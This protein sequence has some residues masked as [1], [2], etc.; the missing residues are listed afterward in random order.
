MPRTDVSRVV[1]SVVKV[2]SP[3]GNIDPLETGTGTTSCG[4]GWATVRLPGAKPVMRHGPQVEQVTVVVIV[5]SWTVSDVDGVSL[6]VVPNEDGWIVGSVMNLVVKSL[7]LWSTD[8]DGWI[9]GSVT[10]LVVRFLLLWSTAEVLTKSMLE[11]MV[12]SVGAAIG[13]RVASSRSSNRLAPPSPRGWGWLGILMGQCTAVCITILV[14]TTGGAVLAPS[15]VVVVA[16]GVG[17]MRSGTGV[18]KL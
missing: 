12:L 10:N 11:V 9:V 7:L 5:T 18:P 1:I 2:L 16:G 4:R 3:R 14:K 13:V 6:A 17:V 15:Q 8:E